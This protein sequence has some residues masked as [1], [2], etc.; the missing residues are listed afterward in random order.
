MQDWKDILVEMAKKLTPPFAFAVLFVVVL[1]QFGAQI[2]AEYTQLVYA[3][4]LALPLLWVG[5][6]LAQVV[7]QSRTAETEKNQQ[8]DQFVV[9]RDSKKSV[10]IQGTRNEVRYIINNYASIEKPSEK[11]GLESQL[12]D[13]LDW[14]SSTYINSRHAV[15]NISFDLRHSHTEFLL[16]HFTNIANTTLS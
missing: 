15:L 10:I 2:P 16:N 12:I 8:A 7:K 14:E 5:V 13:Y 4:G 9:G 1:G 11:A 6:E 3:V